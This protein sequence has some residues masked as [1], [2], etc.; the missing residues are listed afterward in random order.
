MRSFYGGVR[1]LNPDYVGNTMAEIN[2]VLK[3]CGKL[4]ITTPNIASLFRRLRLILGMQPQHETHVHEYTKKKVEELLKMYG[5]KILKTWYSEVNDLT[6]VDAE[7]NEY[8]RLKSYWNLLRFTLK[9][10]KQ[11]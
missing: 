9:K 4:V 6:Y 1:T 7:P 8:Q 3:P 10:T 11:A 2:R 5:F